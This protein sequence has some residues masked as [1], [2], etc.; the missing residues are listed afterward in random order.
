MTLVEDL[1]AL[2]LGGV[3]DARAS[4]TGA[5]E[6]PDLQGLLAGGVGPSVLGDV[7]AALDELRAAAEHPEAL[8]DDV[9]AALPG[10][11]AIP[12]LGELDLDGWE[13]AV[14]EGA[15]LVGDLVAALGGD[16]SRIGELITGAAGDLAPA[17][18]TTMGDYVHVGIDEVARLRRLID[19][20]G[21]GVPPQPDAFA[22]LA[23]DALFSGPGSE[24][25]R[26]RAAVRGL[27]DGAAAISLPR[28]RLAGLLDA[29]AALAA[30]AE[31]GDPRA[32]RAALATLE[33]ARDDTLA[34]IEGDLRLVAERAGALRAP[35]A[36]AV[37]T[38]ASEGL[39]AAGSGILEFLDAMRAE[40]QSARAGIE[41]L[42]P[43]AA[44]AAITAFLDGVE[45]R[46]QELLIDPVEERVDAVEAWVRGL[47]AHLPLRALRAELTGV[48]AQAAAAIED[49]DLDAPAAALRARL[50]ALER[51]VAELDVGAVV[52]AAL[53]AIEGVISGALQAISQALQA[54][55]EAVDA[56]A[57]AAADV[58]GQAVEV[59]RALAGAVQQ[60]KDA[61]DELPIE[62]ARDEVVAAIRELRAKAEELLAEVTLPEGVR[63]LVDQ[64]TAE[65]REVDVEGALLG[66]VDE[67]LADFHVLQDIG[68]VDTVRDVQERLSN[69]VPA[70]IADELQAQ[71]DAV[72]DGIRAFRPD[73]LRAT[74]E[75]FLGEAAGAL[76]DVDLAPVREVVHQPFDLLLRGFDE[77]K[78]SSLLRPVLDAYDELVG[79]A[80][81]PDPVAASQ[82]LVGAAADAAARLAPP[83]TEAAQ[84]VVP[85][86]ETVAAQVPAQLP[87]GVPRPGD[88]VRLFGWLP[89][90]LR[91]ALSQA[92]AEG[93]T[94][95]LAALDDLVGGL[96]G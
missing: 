86:A 70:Q 40:L 66:P 33:R 34:A 25:V 15:E 87:E 11:D 46:A 65:L 28:T 30:A 35:E 27:L 69:L 52:R 92:T 16:L 21:A 59:L 47:F 96:A 56:V 57:D 63:P 54:I 18:L 77:L 85:G 12:G 68:L 9:L 31:S 43:A 71:L 42:D 6:S 48:V 82:S 64:L 80:A 38:A 75:G 55:G 51:Q 88:V 93:R 8:L 50:D 36:L 49:A 39:G 1:Q 53:E 79:T 67:A 84:R 61:I 23:I 95:A 2:D 45:E 72:L 26:V 89:G 41:G 37:V 94:A 83:L 13:A 76:E 91:E 62:A 60:A 17:A 10:L 20:V 7:G 14:R 90:R 4:I 22:R 78:P 81:L 44:H 19:A 73:Q 32:L 58:V 24:L 29:H 5:A 3:V 74:L